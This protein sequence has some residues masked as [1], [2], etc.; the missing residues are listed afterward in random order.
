MKNYGIPDLAVTRIFGDLIVHNVGVIA[1]TEIGIY[2]F[3][4]CEKFVTVASDRVWDLLIMRKVFI[5]LRSFMKMV[6]I[7]V[8][9]LMLL[10]RKL[11]EDGGGQRKKRIWKI[12]RIFN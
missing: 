8:E 7:L 11:I 12:W 5:M 4:G 6:W 3:G 2:D 1:E 10:L 9:L